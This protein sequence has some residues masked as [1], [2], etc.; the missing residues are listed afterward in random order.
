MSEQ[1]VHNSG[2]PNLKELYLKPTVLE[3]RLQKIGL[4]RY[5]LKA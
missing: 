3:M 2:Y 5:L 4:Y 1:F